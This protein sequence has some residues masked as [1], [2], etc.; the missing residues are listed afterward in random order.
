[1]ATNINPGFNPETVSSNQLYNTQIPALSENA[2][3]QEALRLYHYGV[4]GNVPVT[5][6]QISD[7][8]IA[9]HLKFLQTGITTLQ[10]KGVGSSYSKLSPENPENGFVWV[11][12]DSVAPIFQSPPL[13]VPSVAKYQNSAPT[14]N[15]K[16][17]MLWVDKDASP[18]RL[19]VYDAAESLWKVIG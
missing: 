15:L 1:M 10:N 8:T 12:S 17:G 4:G 7:N 6:S 18:L 9:G 19:Y 16:D 2:N 5:N 11:D 13:T 3:I 14:L